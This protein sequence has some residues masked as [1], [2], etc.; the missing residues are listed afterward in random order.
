[1]LG[2]IQNSSMVPKIW[3]KIKKLRNFPNT[4]SSFQILYH[5][6]DAVCVWSIFTIWIHTGYSRFV[7][8][9][10]MQIGSGFLVSAHL[11]ES[12]QIVSLNI[13]HFLEF[14]QNFG[15]AVYFE[16]HIINDA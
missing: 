7:T 12:I 10:I 13:V 9:S 5:F 14:S 15:H 4:Y 16:G 3:V 11:L 1:M 6:G 2:Q 8:H